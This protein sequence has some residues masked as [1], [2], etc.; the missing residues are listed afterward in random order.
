MNKVINTGQSLLLKNK[1]KAKL[2]VK[3]QFIKKSNFR[4]TFYWIYSAT[5]SIFLTYRV[6]CQFV[7]GCCHIAPIVHVSSFLFPD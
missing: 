7:P 6:I 3:H 5:S 1:Q 2:P 4:S